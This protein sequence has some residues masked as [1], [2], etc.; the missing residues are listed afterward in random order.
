MI[1]QTFETDVLQDD[2]AMSDPQPT[3]PQKR[4]GV[5]ISLRWELLIP[6]VIAATVAAAL[7]TYIL[8]PNLSSDLATNLLAGYRSEVETRLAFMP[9]DADLALNDLKPSNL[10]ELI[11]IG[12][13]G[14]PEASTLKNASPVVDETDYLTA[15]IDL[16]DGRRIRVL[17]PQS[18]LPNPDAAR[19]TSALMA[20]LAAGVV[21]IAAFLL[22]E[23]RV[24]GRVNR[25][26]R[27]AEALANG[28]SIARTN[29]T[30]N[31]EIGAI[32]WALDRYTEYVQKRHDSLRLSLRRQRREI[33]HLSAVLEMLPDGVIVQD[34]DGRVVFT[35][36]RAKELLGS[37]GLRSGGL[38]ELTS[39]VTDT[40][41]PALAPGLYA[42]GN[43]TRV[44][45]NGRMLSA[46]VAAVTSFSNQRVGK[47]AL[48]RDITDDVRRERAREALLKRMSDEV[49]RPLAEGTQT[50]S[51]SE[52]GA[53]SSFARE[54]AR[55][56]VALQKLIV[57]M[58]ELSADI[59]TR[60]LKRVQRAIPLE[61]L[62]WAVANEWRQVAQA[63][64]LKLQV[65]V[66]RS[67]LYVLGDERRLRW[68]IGNLIDNAIKY[69]PP[70]GAVSLEIKGD[71]DGM[72]R[73]R[74]RD[75]GVGIAEDELPQVF[76]RFFRGSPV[77]QN[78]RAI[79]V[80]GTGQGLTVAKDIIESHGGRI[81]IKS[82]VTKGTA[83]YFT[84]PLTSPESLSMLSPETTDLR[85]SEPAF[86]DDPL[87][88]EKGDETYFLRPPGM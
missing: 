2:E 81:Q 31:D 4:E 87:D 68:A 80:P 46:Q 62:I 65:Q 10:V 8:A 59:D 44:E 61:T 39:V 56:A 24:I 51:V 22:L 41:G 38:E 45:V 23:W 71:E 86:E 12:V 6:L 53:L 30:P 18:A 29:M 27:T 5:F 21:V 15:T 9:P 43:P 74:I 25:V 52:P 32:G 66:E 33:A 28:G 76:E 3:R 82:D 35:N 57:E 16:D 1:G 83:V 34:S 55:H 47:V 78:G 72:A 54:I 60:A 40:L 13:D 7:V 19:G 14:A 79:R 84:L 77:T 64:N 26:R 63:A 70:G 49:Q 73:L 20:G 67:G 37:H 58:R 69:T 11:L 75:N 36:E 88:D 42:L 85:R 50:R 48:L 17:V